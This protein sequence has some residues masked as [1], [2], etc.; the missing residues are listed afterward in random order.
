VTQL[1]AQ[2]TRIDRDAARAFVDRELLPVADNFD[3]ERAV[4]REFRELVAQ[5]GYYGANIGARF[6]GQG[7][8]AL[9]WG[10]VHEEFGRGCSSMRSLLT[11]HAMVAW[12]IE[13]H[14][15]AAQQ[16][17]WLTQLASGETQA[18]FC[19]SEHEAGSDT[20]AIGTTAQRVADGWRIDGAKAW[21]TGGAVAGLFLVFA[22][23]ED[24][25]GAFLVPAGNEVAV[26]PVDDLLGTRASLVADIVL[27][28]VVV[29]DAA[30]LG[31]RGFTSS[32][33][34]TSVLDVGRFSVASG[35]LGIIQG[36]LDASTDRAA[37]RSIGGRALADYQLTQAKIADMA[38]A[39]VAGRALCERAAHL[40]DAG[41][42]AS[43]TATWVAKYY[44][45]RAAA[46]SASDAVQLHGAAGCC[47]SHRVARY[48]R[49]AKVMEIIEGSNELQQV[50]IAANVRGAVVR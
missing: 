23:C 37:A 35:S 44:T 40:K 32:F 24:G 19:L 9:T 20:E 36:C 25:I 17:D 49:D 31:P 43:V 38:T 39:V 12:A 28:G 7:A 50:V 33:L 11:V 1:A 26:A 27:D 15:S 2:P 29:P 14:G 18:A 48:Y 47:D 5:H 30:R 4:A 42:P 21:I 8:S 41:D 45:S 16:E 46:R 34:L 3:A 13:R 10:A 6:G 22:R